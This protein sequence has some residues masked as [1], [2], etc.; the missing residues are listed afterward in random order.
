[1]ALGGF[2]LLTPRTA[3]LELARKRFNHFQQV[4]SISHGTSDYSTGDAP[5]TI[6]KPIEYSA[7]NS[8]LMVVDAQMFPTPFSFPM[9]EQNMGLF[10]R[11]YDYQSQIN[12][13]DANDYTNIRG[14]LTA[15][16]VSDFMASND[17]T[18][19]TRVYAGA[20]TLN[21]DYVVVDNDSQKTID[22]TEKYSGYVVPQIQWYSDVNGVPTELNEFVVPFFWVSSNSANY[23]TT[24][25]FS[26]IY[27]AAVA[28]TPNTVN[29]GATIPYH[30]AQYPRQYFVK[31]Y[32]KSG[33]ATYDWELPTNT[34]KTTLRAY[35]RDLMPWVCL[36]STDDTALTGT[37]YPIDYTVGTEYLL[38]NVSL[39]NTSVVP[40]FYAYPDAESIISIFDDLGVFVSTDLTEILQYAPPEDEGINPDSPNEELPFFP[41][42]TT[43]T[44]EIEPA[45]ITPSTFGHAFIYTPAATKNFLEWVCNNTVNIENW[46]RLFANPVDVI[47]GINMYN[48]DI[49]AHD[50]AHVSYS[51]QTN[52]LGV[53][54]DIGNYQMIGG[55]NNIVDGGTLRLQ[56]YYGNYA[57]F[58]SMTYQMFIPFVGFTD[59]RACDVVNKTLHL[60]YAVDFATGAAVAFVNSDDKLI[61][62][63][64]CTVAGKIPVST[65]DKNNQMINN[66]LAAFSGLG[67]L[68]GGIASGNVGGGV[69]SLLNGLGGLQL[70]T[71]YA[72]KGSLSSV[73]IY[74]LLPAFI[75]RTR[76]DLF[77]PSNDTQ[78]KGARYQRAAGAPSTQFDTLLNCVDAGGFVQSDVVYLTSQTATETEK[79]QIIDLIKSGIYL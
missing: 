25:I 2:E 32:L 11:L 26:T 9:P 13:D 48:L 51:A 43:D 19:I 61:Y 16:P 79:Q 72:N 76:Y 29:F 1:M 53:T 68:I 38:G 17:I 3:K 52:I 5:T 44:T 28:T 50:A 14:Y 22:D 71:N 62:T 34:R 63:S 27:S 78:Y 74:K 21:V 49:V 36:T 75:E 18:K 20:D 6:R 56:A 41:D 46:K 64:P 65:S 69:S 47:L 54:T 60:Y 39:V 42:N 70:Q 45:Y 66:T 31:S 59:L 40:E 30:K 37:L 77:L 58:T 15:V 4:T 67:G 10:P 35:D 57:D 12:A 7:G 23:F 8:Y 73:N 24:N 33:V 55:Y